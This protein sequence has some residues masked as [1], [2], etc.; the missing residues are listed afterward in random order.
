MSRPADTVVD[1]ATRRGI[2]DLSR[3]APTRRSTGVEHAPASAPN[4]SNRTLHVVATPIGNLGDISFR[5]ADVL[6]T[7]KLIVAEDTRRSGKLLAHLGIRVPLLSFHE[8]NRTARIPR[9]LAALAEGDVAIVTDAG[10]PSVSDPGQDLV[11]AARASGFAV[12]AVPG[13]SALAASIMVSGIAADVVHFVG[14]LPRKA[15]ERRRILEMAA[16]WPGAVVFFEAPHRLIE[17]LRDAATVFGDRDASVCN[18][19]TKRFE[20]VWQ[21]CLADLVVI[22]EKDPPRGEFTVVV[23]PPRVVPLS[24]GTMPLPESSLLR[25][26]YDALVQTTGDRKAALRA[27]AMETGHPRKDVY[28]RVVGESDPLDRG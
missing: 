28:A 14:F 17:A 6:R 9:I 2:S 10:T 23:G 20:R 22:F 18:D 1:G 19:L 11:A 8:H 15:N 16:K 26:R 13:P 5:A 7:V 25:A 21:A 24:G 4:S 3:E 27:L 12:V